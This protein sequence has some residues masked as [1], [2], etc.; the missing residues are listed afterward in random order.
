M[1]VEP[2]P[3]YSPGNKRGHIVSKRGHIVV[4][5]RGHIVVH[6]RGHIVHNRGH[7]GPKRQ[8]RLDVGGAFVFYILERG[9]P[10]LVDVVFVLMEGVEREEEGGGKKLAKCLPS[11]SY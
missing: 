9:I 10:L 5:K 1:L 11:P 7:I 3:A 6:K 2:T 4:H 8:N